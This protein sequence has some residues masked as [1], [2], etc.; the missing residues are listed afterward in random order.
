MALNMARARSRSSLGDFLLRLGLVLLCKEIPAADGDGK[1]NG[2]A[3]LA[4]HGRGF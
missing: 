4:V 1:G 2:D 3:K